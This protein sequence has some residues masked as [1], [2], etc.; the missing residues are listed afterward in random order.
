MLSDQ[1]L[2]IPDWP[3]P[4]N[5]K[6]LQTTRAGGISQP[7]YESLNLG[8][9]VGDAPLDVAANRQCL[10]RWVPT[11]PVWLNQVHGIHVIDAGTAS[12][13]PDADAAFA[14]T[15][16][17]VCAVM[18]ADCLP[19]LICD[20][21]GT[22]VAAVHAG[23]RSLLDGVIEATVAK[24]RQPGSELLA[25][26]GPAIGPEAFEVGDEVRAAFIAHDAHAEQAFKPAAAG[27]WLGDIFT[28]GRQRLANV[29]VQNVYGG[30]LCTHSNAERFFSFRRDNATGRMASLIWLE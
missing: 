29:G 17:T 7:P 20:K 14:R 13:M 6:A 11:E 23:W 12:C 1:D 10:N 15:R 21:A 27:K 5:V 16:H 3:A 19:V 22:V 9:H 26:L 30:G 28:L 8:M 25:W 24:M 18:T 4:A 2:I